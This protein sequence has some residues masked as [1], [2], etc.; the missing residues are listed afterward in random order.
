MAVRLAFVV[1]LAIF[2]TT[3]VLALLTTARHLLRETPNKPQAPINLKG[4]SALA[5]A[6]TSPALP[7]SA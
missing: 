2:C 7:T 1:F 4:A 5:S 6:A 3:L